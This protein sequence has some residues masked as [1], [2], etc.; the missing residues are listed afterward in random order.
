[1][2]KLLLFLG[3]MIGMI[4]PIMAQDGA[5]MTGSFMDYF[6][7]LTAL[8]GLNVIITAAILKFFK[9]EPTKLIKQLISIGIALIL[10]VVGWFMQWGI[11][12]GT[13][14]WMILVYAVG[15]AFPSNGFFDIIKA[16]IISLAKK[17]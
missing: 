7:T 10:C 14:W 16:L 12:T 4:F 8:A 9:T 15:V 3:L 17:K 1:M 6:A 11:F 5:S 2:K 13:E